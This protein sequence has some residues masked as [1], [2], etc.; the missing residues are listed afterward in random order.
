MKTIFN[1]NRTINQLQSL[2]SVS[3]GGAWFLSVMAQ[4]VAFG[5]CS[6]K[7]NCFILGAINC[8]ASSMCCRV[9][10][11]GSREVYFSKWRKICSLTA[12]TAAAPQSSGAARRCWFIGKLIIKLLLAFS[13][14]ETV[15]NRKFLLI[16]KIERFKR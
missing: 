9:F 1:F 2:F 15:F 8:L 16:K 5:G 6:K 12:F 7:F 3:A 13:R 14:L 4:G 11:F 10:F